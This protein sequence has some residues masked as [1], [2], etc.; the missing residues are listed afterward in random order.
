M[1]DYSIKNP[2]GSFP[3]VYICHKHECD[4]EKP[5]EFAKPNKT[6]SIKNLLN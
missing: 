1:D 3:K 5:R 4:I 2:T 6:L